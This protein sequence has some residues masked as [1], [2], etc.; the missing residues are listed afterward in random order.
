MRTA[1]AGL[2]AALFLTMAFGA[3]AQDR[4]PWL[5]ADGMDIVDASGKSVTLRGMNFGGS[6]VI[7]LWQSA[8]NLSGKKADQI[9][10]KDEKSF[11]ESMQQRFGASK[12]Q[13]IRRTWR[14]SWANEQDVAR[15]AALGCN[16]VRIPFYHGLLEDEAHPGVIQPEGAR[17]L[18]NLLDACA[19]YRVY[20]VLDMHGAPGGQS[21]EDHTGEKGRDELFKSAEM[22][23]RTAYL[24]TA[25]A[26]R[27]RD[28]PEIAGYDLLNEPMGAPDAKSLYAVHDLLYKAVRS[29]DTKHIVIVEDGYKGFNTF[30][31]PSDIGWQN[32]CYS[33][34]FYQFGANSIR[35]HEKFIAET[36]PQIRKTQ[37]SL[38]VPVYIGE[39]STISDRQGGA[40]AM[41]AYFKA[42]ND[43]RWSWTP[44]T[45]KQLDAYNGFGSIWGLYTNAARFNRPNLYTDSFETLLAKFHGYDTSNLFVQT[46]YRDAIL[47]ATK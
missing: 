10:I 38:N 36:L 28:R 43:Y 33:V 15:L 16:V 45:Y 40:G 32:V 41:A 24:W 8:V 17:L 26:R 18:E 35:D 34:H 21:G 9:E 5:R 46:D 44:W 27:Y 29:V 39:F 11:W 42:F 7:E 14:T 4:L 30:P 19:K 31:K 23:K 25:I 22:Q 37:E 47:A 13:E 6:F 1:H 2:L 20:A 3:S 12:M